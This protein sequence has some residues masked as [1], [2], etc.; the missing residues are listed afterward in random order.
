MPLNKRVPLLGLRA[1]KKVLEP[2]TSGI[3]AQGTTLL[4]HV[5][6]WGYNSTCYSPLAHPGDLAEECPDIPDGRRRKEIRFAVSTLLC[7][8]KEGFF[9]FPLKKSV[10]FNFFLGQPIPMEER[11]WSIEWPPVSHRV[12]NLC[13]KRKDWADCCRRCQKTSSSNCSTYMMPG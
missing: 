7:C 9:I 12:Q 13:S 1:Q 4:N 5:I 8:R 10:P 2:N 6:K 11:H 3:W